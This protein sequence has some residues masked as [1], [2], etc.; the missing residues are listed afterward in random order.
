MERFGSLHFVSRSEAIDADLH[1]PA[2]DEEA[3][4]GAHSS[5]SV[6][7]NEDT[8]NGNNCIPAPDP[9]KTTQPKAA[10]SAPDDDA[11][12]K[13]AP[14]REKKEKKSSSAEVQPFPKQ[15]GA[16]VV[17]DTEAWMEKMRTSAIVGRDGQ[18]SESEADAGA[19]DPAGEEEEAA[20]G[21]A[22]FNATSCG[23]AS[24][25]PPSKPREGEEPTEQKSSAKKKTADENIRPA[26]IAPDRGGSDSDS[27]E[28]KEEKSQHGH[29][30][31]HHGRQH[32]RG[33]D[34]SYS[35]E[36]TEE[37]E[38]NQ[39]RKEETSSR[40]GGT[41]AS[42]KGA[43]TA[44]RQVGDES[45]ARDAK[46]EAEAAEE[47]EEKV[48]NPPA[49]TAH[50]Q[51][52]PPPQPDP[53]T[54]PDV[55]EWFASTL[56]AGWERS[57]ASAVTD[58]AFVQMFLELAGRE[59]AAS[60][61]AASAAFASSASA[62]AGGGGGTKS[63]AVGEG[64]ARYQIEEISRLHGEYD[65]AC[66]ATAA[67]YHAGS[68]G[69][70]KGG[71]S[72]AKNKGTAAA[73]SA[74]TAAATKD[75]ALSKDAG[76]GPGSA[77]T[78]AAAAT[79]ASTTI[80]GTPD[81]TVPDDDAY[82]I[83]GEGKGKD[84]DEDK[85]S[86]QGDGGSQ[87][88][89]EDAASA[90]LPASTEEAGPTMII[91][92]KS[93]LVVPVTAARTSKAAASGTG[94]AATTRA[95][96]AAAERTHNCTG[97]SPASSPSAS[98]NAAKAAAPG[99][100]GDIGSKPSFTALGDSPS[101]VHADVEEA[102]ARELA[103]TT[104]AVA[105]S[106]NKKASKKRAKKARQQANK[107][108]RA[109][110][111]A[112]QAMGRQAAGAPPGAAPGSSLSAAASPYC[113]SP[114]SPGAAAMASLDQTELLRHVRIVL[115]SALGF[116]STGKT[117]PSG[118]QDWGKPFGPVLVLDP[119]FLESNAF[120]S[121]A[122]RIIG[123]VVSDAPFLSKSAADWPSRVS[124]SATSSVPLSILL[125][126][127][128]ER[129]IR[130]TQARATGVPSDYDTAKE[131]SGALESILVTSSSGLT[132]A[133]GTD[134]ALQNALKLWLR[135]RANENDE[136]VM[137]L[138]SKVHS[139]MHEDLPASYAFR[140]EDIVAAPLH[141]LT[142]S[143][144]YSQSTERSRW[145]N[146]TIIPPLRDV[147]KQMQTIPV[148][149]GSD[150]KSGGSSNAGACAGADSSGNQNTPS[151][152][153]KKKKKKSK[154]K[155]AT[156]DTAEAG[157][158][159]YSNVTESFR[160]TQNTGWATSTAPK[161]HR[162][163]P[164]SSGEVP[165]I[166]PSFSTDQS[167]ADSVS[168][169]HQDASPTQPKAAAVSPSRGSIT[170]GANNNTVVGLGRMMEEEEHHDDGWET[171]PAKG[172]EKRGNNSATKKSGT[173]SDNKGGGAS[174]GGRQQQQQQQQHQQHQQ[175]QQQAQSPGR[176]KKNKGKAARKKEQARRLVDD[177]VSGILDNGK[178]TVQ[179][180]LL[181]FAIIYPSSFLSP[182][183]I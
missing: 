63:S 141:L 82:R 81:A 129:A 181:S 163:S 137:L 57:A 118:G 121:L 8:T 103:A 153:K 84:E 18:P 183:H 159:L 150:Q 87:K 154:K 176:K 123:Q 64:P 5:S 170:I 37:A 42:G 67:A 1:P 115:P 149:I 104:A 33:K 75:G 44:R 20:T 11:N 6:R 173:G 59:A 71:K 132:V 74:A 130:G 157:G 7:D 126:A 40:T 161:D 99:D 179:S 116:A 66:A 174:G 117:P 102:A 178:S 171:V 95:V 93:G 122:D 119:E 38:Q 14:E 89:K 21:T 45:K 96:L 47:G 48:P 165:P 164:S 34:E 79:T 182:T 35:A 46:A 43:P 3:E 106:S 23:G 51:P 146:S 101:K 85:A 36:R 169:P 68:G 152:S 4:A 128:F 136:G 39:K 25:N 158:D 110:Q 144:T 147:K 17:L 175:H 109:K 145:W 41:S 10:A 142:V 97:T 180:I 69:K 162:Q 13:E 49:A 167:S 177:I 27:E 28:K 19:A 140:L 134:V 58:P 56:T 143:K 135:I 72:R 151:K 83:R 131:Q 100:D 61:A 133:A 52:P 78:A 26:T 80:T 113:F 155:K 55:R 88:K 108:V 107:V 65:R 114:S 112:A 32:P 156:A 148:L 76:A 127:K 120:L 30:G 90:T 124:R 94:T 22:A 53:Q 98:S 12:Q 168:L 62:S 24:D 15:E 125:L 160:T 50:P 31:H 91:Q 16:A 70:R 166:Q 9:T 54:L 172:S 138:S 92:Y 105:E 2:A 139:D 73:A 86:D 60:S 77:P 29:R 111:A